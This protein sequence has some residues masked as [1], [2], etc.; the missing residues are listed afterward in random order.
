MKAWEVA[1][2]ESIRDTVAR[3]NANGDTGRFAQV[4]ELFTVD[5][6]MELSGRTYTGRDE[7][8][9]IFTGARD[10]P[11]AGSDRGYV[12]HFT[13]THQI[14]LVDESNAVGR[15][16]FQVLTEV[17]LDHW[18]RYVD[19]YRVEDDRWKLAH[20]KVTVDGQSPGSTFPAGS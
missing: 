5:A 20:R 16:Y 12:R 19:R 7:I 15:L 8:I 9:T 17:G 14:D 6:V 13:A 4:I 10:R 1:A 2:R 3:Y 18:G 11:S